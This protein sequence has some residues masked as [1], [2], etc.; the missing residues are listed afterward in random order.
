MLLLFAARRL[1][2][3]PEG[4]GQGMGTGDSNPW[5]QCVTVWPKGSAELQ[6]RRQGPVSQAW[7]GGLGGGDGWG[8]IFLK[9]YLKFFGLR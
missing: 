2:S 9:D 3:V 4:W 8:G 6:P 7:G 5:E 1:R